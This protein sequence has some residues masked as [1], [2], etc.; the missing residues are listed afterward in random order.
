[1]TITEEELELWRTISER[2]PE[3]PSEFELWCR[4][5]LSHLEELVELDHYETGE[6]PEQAY[7]DAANWVAQ[8]GVFALGFGS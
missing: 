6:L 7:Y 8:A 2:G 1:M 5:T 3:N 4:V